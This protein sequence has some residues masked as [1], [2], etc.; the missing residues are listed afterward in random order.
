MS[1]EITVEVK[2]VYGNNTIYPVCETAK[3]FAGLAGTKTLTNDAIRLIKSQGYTVKV[4]A[5][6]VTV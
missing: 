3:F 5:P 1:N 2:N 4:K 6:E